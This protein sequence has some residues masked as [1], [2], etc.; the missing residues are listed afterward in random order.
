MTVRVDTRLNEG[1]IQQKHDRRKIPS[2]FLA[3]EKPLSNI[4]DIL[5]VWIS[6][7]EFPVDDQLC[8]ICDSRN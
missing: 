6:K 1:I 7:T 3:P 2:P 4:T 8:L 5:Y